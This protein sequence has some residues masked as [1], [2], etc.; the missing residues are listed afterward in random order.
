MC[1]EVG[2]Y[3]DDDIKLIKKLVKKRCTVDSGPLSD[4]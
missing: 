4:V 1:L 2:S 3:G